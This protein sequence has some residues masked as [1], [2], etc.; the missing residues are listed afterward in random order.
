MTAQNAT[1]RY[2][3]MSQV[4][5]QVRKTYQ[6]KKCPDRRRQLNSFSKTLE[7]WG[8]FVVYDNKEL[9][10]TVADSISYRLGVNKRHVKDRLEQIHRIARYDA[11][12]D[13]I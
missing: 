6:T 13:N 3:T 5:E 12:E 7:A 1:P 10:E 2:V 4:V 8:D 11:E 9:R